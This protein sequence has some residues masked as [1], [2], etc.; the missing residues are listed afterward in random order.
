MKCFFCIASTVLLLLFGAVLGNER[1]ISDMAG[2][3]Q[4][5][6]VMMNAN[7]SETVSLKCD[8]NF[9]G[10][11]GLLPLGVSANG[12]VVHVFKGVFKGNGHWIRGLH[13]NTIG[14]GCEVA[15]F[16]GHIDGA[17]ISGLKFDKECEFVGIYAG[18]LT[19]K[20]NNYVETRISDIYNYGTIEGEYIGGIVGYSYSLS[21]YIPFVYTNCHNHGNVTARIKN[22]MTRTYISAGGLIGAHY[23][24]PSNYYNS[25][26]T[27]TDCSND[28]PVEVLV[29][30]ITDTIKKL[31]CT[32]GG[33]VGKQ[34]YF[35]YGDIG[36]FWYNNTGSVSII[37]DE[38]YY[39]TAT[40][41]NEYDAIAGGFIGHV[42]AHS[43][44]NH[45]KHSI[46]MG[47]VTVSKPPLSSD[48]QLAPRCYA[49]GISGFLEI[50]NF[51]RIL[52]NTANLGDVTC[53]GCTASG[54]DNSQYDH[55]RNEEDGGEDDGTRPAYINFLN[56]GTVTGDNAYGISNQVLRSVSNIV[57]MGQVQGKVESKSMYPYSCD[58]C[59]TTTMFVL[60]GIGSSDEDEFITF[61]KDENNTYVFEDNG[62]MKKVSD[63]LNMRKT[64]LDGYIWPDSLI[65]TGVIVQFS[66]AYTATY[67]VERGTTLK[68]IYNKQY[69][70]FMDD[71]NEASESL[72]FL[73]DTNLFT[74]KNATFISIYVKAE[75]DS[76][77]GVIESME[78]ISPE[79]SIFSYTKENGYYIFSYVTEAEMEST[80]TDN[81]KN[82]VC[83]GKRCSVVRVSITYIEP[84]S[85]SI[86]SKL[87]LE[88]T[89]LMMVILFCLSSF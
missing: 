10:I 7:N 26:V 38:K 18:S 40:S 8:L 27:Y 14:L 45:V 5:R 73:H 61:E 39:T 85:L 15:G 36:I 42:R 83:N 29:T 63:V 21:Q 89:T 58:N 33:L 13:I 84:L 30:D 37:V 78:G 47:S 49:G 87:V 32:C 69:R 66:G 56:G 46:N 57:S 82:N 12:S 16:F 75:N 60:R 74:Y 35:A 79:G 72:S 20:H 22:A 23:Y 86:A 25:G 11:E 19:G 48:T 34:E 6:A 68:S 76:I 70:V 44:I 55:Y 31:Y 71:G 9:T 17:N 51:A 41:L 50:H 54:M 43:S 28:A 65:K 59:S 1:I 77:S 53:D 81:A 24:G 80:I 3:E 67:D 62:S 64:Y 52:E 2:F 88:L 4:F